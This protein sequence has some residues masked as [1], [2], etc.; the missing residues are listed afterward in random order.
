MNITRISGRESKKFDDLLTILIN[1]DFDE[2]DKAFT[3][4]IGDA[5]NSFEFCCSSFLKKLY[6][7]CP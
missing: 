2:L 3:L 7:L 1:I 5:V 6:E 4:S